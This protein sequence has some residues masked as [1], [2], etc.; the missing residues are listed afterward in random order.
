[1]T[2]SAIQQDVP[3]E[4]E[5]TPVKREPSAR[6]LAMEALSEKR[7]LELA[8]E[9]GTATAE[10]DPDIDPAD[11][12]AEKARLAVEHPTEKPT[13]VQQQLKAQLQ[14]PEDIGAL[15]TRVKIDGVE[16]EVSVDDM[17]REY[18]K[19]RTADK[20]LAEVAEQRR[21]LEQEQLAAQTRAVAKDVA[22][23]PAA[24]KEFTSA[25]F[26]G[27]EE[28]ASAA[29]K[30]AVS[31]AVQ[32]AV[33]TLGRST[34]TPQ[35]DVAAI[36]Q[37]VEQ[38][39][40]I[41]SV[42]ERSKQDYPQMYSDPDIEA[43]GAAKIQRVMSEGNT[44]EQALSQV[45]TDLASKFNWTTPGRQ[46]ATEPTTRTAKLERKAAI[47]NVSGINVKS[48]STE[49]VPLTNSQIIADIAKARGQQV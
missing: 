33:T 24:T 14:E 15:R 43:L 6:E 44:F 35:V 39:L 36:A 23:D 16:S 2:T 1:M 46:A 25:I 34:A 47:D 26:E 42:L 27:D 10:V 21:V 3:L 11:A 29:F 7:D 19:G 41:K 18:Q 40:V 32:E 4:N 49:A 48:S 30:K 8:S 9:M 13:E 12:E 5:P 20:R 37:Q 38:Q 45:S 28:A 22:I 17:R 31:S